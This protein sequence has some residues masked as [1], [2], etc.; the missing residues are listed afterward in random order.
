MTIHSWITGILRIVTGGPPRNYRVAA[1]IDRTGSREA[2]LEG[3]ATVGMV[4]QNRPAHHRYGVIERADRP[5][6][7]EVWDFYRALPSEVWMQPPLPSVREGPDLEALI[8]ATVM[9]YDQA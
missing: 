1:W 5:G 2:S 8:M 3:F 6:H 7:Y 9:T 4:Y